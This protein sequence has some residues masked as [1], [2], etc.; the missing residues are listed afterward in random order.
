MTKY[1]LLQYLEWRYPS[2]E[3]WFI[4]GED[5]GVVK[6]CF[7]IDPDEDEDEESKDAYQ[8]YKTTKRFYAESY[9]N[10]I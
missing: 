2:R 10:Q 3:D 9:R 7:N 4:C 8:K 6:V 5:E 1:D